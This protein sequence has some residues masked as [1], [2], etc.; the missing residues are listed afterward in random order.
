MCGGDDLGMVDLL[1]RRRQCRRVEARWDHVCRNHWFS[2][3][4]PFDEMRRWKWSCSLIPSTQSVTAWTPQGMREGRQN[5]PGPPLCIARATLGGRRMSGTNPWRGGWG[6]TVGEE[7]RHKNTVKVWYCDGDLE[8][9]VA[10]VDP[11]ADQRRWLNC[12]RN[13]IK[14]ARFAHLN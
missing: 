9:L 14:F 8:S 1:W 11:K 7:N 5:P 12:I 2:V 10:L 6:G 13:K 4:G 3:L